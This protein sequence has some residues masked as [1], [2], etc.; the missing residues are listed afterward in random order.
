MSV[1]GCL[2]VL[3]RRMEMFAEAIRRRE[4]WPMIEW[5]YDHVS[6]AVRRLRSEVPVHQP[7]LFDEPE[8]HT[9]ARSTDPDTSHAA[10]AYPRG[11]SQRWRILRAHYL[12]DLGGLTDEELHRRLP[13]MRLNSLTTRR[14]EL[15]GAGWLYDTGERREASGG[16]DQ[17]V[18]K[19]TDV[20]HQAWKEERDLVRSI[21]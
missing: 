12:E 3:E 5:H 21:S 1:D 17:I 11:S 16:V 8:P 4:N 7:T 9:K 15:A 14:S 13:D 20:G 18:W 6:R 10:A 2:Q 19:M